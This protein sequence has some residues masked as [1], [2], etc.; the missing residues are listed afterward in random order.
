MGNCNVNWL[1]HLLSQGKK[2]Y[3]KIFILYPDIHSLDEGSICDQ[4]EETGKNIWL[5]GQKL[6]SWLQYQ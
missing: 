3:N 6:Y 2:I 1:L 5:A 4:K